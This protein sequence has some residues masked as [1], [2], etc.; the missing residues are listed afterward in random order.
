MVDAHAHTIHPNGSAE[1]HG[2]TP[3]T[4]KNLYPGKDQRKAWMD[5]T[6]KLEK[7]I[8]CPMWQQYF[9]QKYEWGGQVEGDGVDGDALEY[10]TDD[11]EKAL[12]D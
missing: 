1:L 12:F 3:K 11:E 4:I 6:I 10:D 5:M 2:V 7:Y 9:F 8:R